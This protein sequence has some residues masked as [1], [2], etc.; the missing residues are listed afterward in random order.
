MNNSYAGG[1]PRAAR[2]VTGIMA[3]RV[4]PYQVWVSDRHVRMA[5]DVSGVGLTE[6]TRLTK[7]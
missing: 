4:Y 2:P 3:L 6:T 7:L 1:A 5:Q